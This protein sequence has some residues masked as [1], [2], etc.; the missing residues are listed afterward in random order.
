MKH[1][2]GPLPHAAPQLRMAQMLQPSALV[3]QE[4]MRIR[5]EANNREM[6]KPKVASFDA[7]FFVAS[8]ISIFVIPLFFLLHL[9]I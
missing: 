7:L 3:P 9:L 5:V 2:L 8:S 4:L 1:P 6:T